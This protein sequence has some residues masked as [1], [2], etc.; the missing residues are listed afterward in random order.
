MD[1]DFFL[2]DVPEYIPQYDSNIKYSYS[3][4]Q[5]KKN[6]YVFCVVFLMAIVCIAIIKSR[7]MVIYMLIWSMVWKK[8]LQKKF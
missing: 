6:Y 8:I 4:T 3:D 5:M 7:L 1:N 2:L